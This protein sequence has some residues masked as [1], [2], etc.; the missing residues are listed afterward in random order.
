MTAARRLAAIMAIEVSGYS[1]LMGEDEAGDARSGVKR[2]IGSHGVGCW[3][4][5]GSAS[6]PRLSRPSTPTRAKP[7]AVFWKAYNLRGYVDVGDDVPYFTVANA[8]MA[9]SSP[10]MSAKDRRRGRNQTD[11]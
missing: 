3:S 2:V 9:G 7:L 5:D 6:W 10:A 1:R 11:Q 8:W 4:A